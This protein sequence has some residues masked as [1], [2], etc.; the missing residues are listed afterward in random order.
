MKKFSIFL[1]GA[2]A[3]AASS[4][5]DAP[6]PAPMQSN[7]QEP[8][9][10]AGDIKGE[11]AGALASTSVLALEDSKGKDIEMF[12]FTETKDVPAGGE[13][14][15][16][17]QLSNTEDFTRVETL[18]V[19]MLDGVAYVSAEE[20]NTAHIA[21]FGKSPKAK[22][23]Y[24]R[25][26]VYIALNGTDYRYDSESYYA[27]TGTVKE[28]CMDAGF[29][30]YDNYYFLGNATT[31]E[32]DDANMASF[33]FSHSDADVY[34]D[35]VFTFKFEVTQEILDGNGGGCYWKV[36]SQQAVESGEWTNVY[37]PEMDG[38]E[39]LSGFLVGDGAAQAG[40]IVAPGKYRITV[41]ME[42]MTYDIQ[43]ITRPD[44]VAVPSNANGWN[45]SGS[46]LY[47]SNKDDK[48]YFCGAA[49]VNNTDGGFKFIWDGAWWSGAKYDAAT[50]PKGAPIFESPDNIPA[51]VDGN[52]LYW[53]TVS[54]E[55]MTYTMAEITSIGVVGAL[56]GWSETSP[57]EL[58][59]DASLLIWSGD[60]EL[61]G[62]WKIIINH[63]WNSNYG[64]PVEDPTFDGDN[65][66]GYEGL[67]TVAID[68]S[69]NRPV[70]TVTP[71]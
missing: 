54:T 29:V 10:A 52:A 30:I 1:L 42:A 47:W 46:R 24:Y 21:L 59:P 58:T 65:I 57:I 31:W 70:I 69:G 25:V 67:H 62:I 45:D 44:W 51:P 63:S 18:S 16:K 36:A 55:D 39:E 15:C 66:S 13:V 64:A 43:P 9:L 4:C 23:A 3:M 48:P 53:F 27:A 5:E 7:P 12:R 26:P 41:N 68:F 28:T 33:A 20:W 37:G 8:V 32:L 2:L 22:T 6:E 61:T 50:Y 40:K 34:D 11:V 60:V 71:K 14:F 49:R 56:N 19:N 38:D 35:P 17:M